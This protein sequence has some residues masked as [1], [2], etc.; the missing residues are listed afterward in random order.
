MREYTDRTEPP[1]RRKAKLE[2]RIAVL[3]PNVALGDKIA[4]RSVRAMRRELAGLR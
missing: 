2:G 3:L 4:A 1:A